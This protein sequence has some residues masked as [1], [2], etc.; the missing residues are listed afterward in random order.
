MSMK[1]SLSFLVF[2]SACKDEST[3]QACNS[4]LGQAIE[5]SMG[6]HRLEAQLDAMKGARDPPECPVCPPQ[7]RCP[8]DSAALAKGDE[9]IRDMQTVTDLLYRYKTD[10]SFNYQEFLDQLSELVPE[11]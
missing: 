8:D 4:A 1:M 10:N 5:V 11:K 6:L 2:F 7:V 9:A 3:L